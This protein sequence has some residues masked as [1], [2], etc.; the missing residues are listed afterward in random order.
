[1]KE[2][3]AIE[4]AAR[5]AGELDGVEE[6]DEGWWKTSLKFKRHIDDAHRYGMD[7]SAYVTEVYSC[8]NIDYCFINLIMKS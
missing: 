5:I 4:D 8:Q 2:T 6:T 7:T 3:S 1:M